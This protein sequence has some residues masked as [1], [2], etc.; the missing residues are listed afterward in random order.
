M[1]ECGVSRQ[2]ASND[3]PVRAAVPPDKPLAVALPTSHRREGRLARHA[4]LR[5]LYDSSCLSGVGGGR[6]FAVIE[7]S[8]RSHY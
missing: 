7:E 1:V 5:R 6:G 2:L 3:Q 8:Y 4:I